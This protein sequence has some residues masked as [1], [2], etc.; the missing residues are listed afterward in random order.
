MG[1][2]DQQDVDVSQFK[3]VFRSKRELYNFLA[4]DVEASLPPCE[5]ISIFFL[6]EIM[7]GAKKVFFRVLP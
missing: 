7:N 1:E 6:K 3:S 2:N 5:N 4:I